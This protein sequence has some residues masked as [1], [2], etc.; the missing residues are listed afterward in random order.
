MR[1]K[2]ETT[3]FL[4]SVILIFVSSGICLLLKTNNGKV[5]VHDLDVENQDG[6]L[7]HARL[8]RPVSASSMNPRPSVLL[9][10][11]N[12]CGLSC[13]DYAAAE[14]TRNGFVVLNIE[15]SGE[16]YHYDTENSID[17]GYTYLRTRS[18]TDH[19][20]TS[21]AAWGNAA[22]TAARSG[23]IGDFSSV[24][25]IASDSK[26]FHAK[27]KG[28]RIY[29]EDKIS[30]MIAGRKTLSYLTETFRSEGGLIDDKEYREISSS[31]TPALLQGL[32]LARIIMTVSAVLL[33][34]DLTLFLPKNE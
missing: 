8:Y 16:K 7:Y 33:A 25:L 3:M 21:L 15:N 14:L 22:E 1:K 28:V 24:V 29:K 32:R 4:I 26:H 10:Y 12:S 11:G 5:F 6:V 30:E 20:K 19:D 9:S 17:A 18:F 23:S 13:G 34:A 31:H 2:I 27:Q